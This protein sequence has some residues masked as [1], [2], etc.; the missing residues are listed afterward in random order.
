MLIQLVRRT[1]NLYDSLKIEHQK[2]VQRLKREIQYLKD[3]NRLLEI[4]LRNIKKL[5]SKERDN[6]SIIIARL[7][8][9]TYPKDLMQKHN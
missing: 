3:E 8:T 1:F 6:R 4:R 9:N 2:E 7:D 5:L